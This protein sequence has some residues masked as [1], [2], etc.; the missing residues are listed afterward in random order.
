MENPKDRA[1]DA[2]QKHEYHSGERHRCGPNA[3]RPKAW[4]HTM[5][6]SRLHTC[7]PPYTALGG[8][9]GLCT[10]RAWSLGT[11]KLSIVSNTAVLTRPLSNT[12]SVPGPGLGPALKEGPAHRAARGKHSPIPS[13]R[14]CKG[15]ASQEPR[16]RQAGPSE[17]VS[18]PVAVLGRSE[19]G[20]VL[21]TATF[22]PSDMPFLAPSPKLLMTPHQ[23]PAL[24]CSLCAD[25]ESQSAGLPTP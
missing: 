6:G 15:Q 7:S 18:G 12:F 2:N 1:R 21:P 10:L 22:P 24:L 17:G 11:C 20:T 8:L 16:G 4:I 14:C 3:P 19:L 23:H 13:D 5:P 25:C 9:R